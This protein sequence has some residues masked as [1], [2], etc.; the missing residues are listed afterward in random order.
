MKQPISRRT[1][2][3]DDIEYGEGDCKALAR[4]KPASAV[5]N[6][7]SH[8]FFAENTN[9]HAQDISPA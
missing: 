4:N 5:N 3:T 7:D 8:E 1:G 2:G 9:S 6:A